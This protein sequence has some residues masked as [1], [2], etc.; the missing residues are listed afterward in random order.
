MYLISDSRPTQD[1]VNKYVTVMKGARAEVL[2]KRAASKLRRKQDELVNNYTYTKEDID[3]NLQERKTTGKTAN[4]SLEQTRAE[5][6]VQGARLAVADAQ[7]RLDDAQRTLLEL[8]G[9]DKEAELERNVDSARKELDQAKRDLALR[10]EEQV[11][12]MDVADKRKKKLTSRRNDMNWAKVNQ[13]NKEL[14]ETADFEAFKEQKARAEAESKSG[15]QPKFNPYA[16]RKV[17]PKMLW[18]VGQKEEKDDDPKEKGPETQIEKVVEEKNG[19]HNESVIKAAQTAKEAEKAA[20]SHQFNL[21][22]DAEVEVGAALGAT[23]RLRAQRLI[24]KGISLTEYQQRKAAGT[25]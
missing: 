8:G 18:E 11:K 1:D 7:S 16:R 17:K 4:L 23:P 2:S 15:G 5:L 9:S 25:L 6:A 3:R 12:V 14:N 21:D 24:R 19:H 22:E 13:R 10:L 20:Q